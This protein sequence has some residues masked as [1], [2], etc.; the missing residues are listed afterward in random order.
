MDFYESIKEYTRE[1]V[2]EF[3]KECASFTK[4]SNNIDKRMK[5][6]VSKSNDMKYYGYKPIVISLNSKELL[7]YINHIVCFDEK[8]ETMKNVRDI[9]FKTSKM[10]YEKFNPHLI[11]TFANEINVVFYDNENGMFN[12]N[13]N[14]TITF[15]SS[16]ASVRVSNIIKSTGLDLDIH[17]TAKFTEFDVD[18]EV[19]NYLIWRQMDCRRNTITILYK[20]LHSEMILDNRINIENLKISSMIDE[21]KNFDIN[22]ETDFYNFLVGN[23]IKKHI[24][25][26]NDKVIKLEHFKFSDNFKDNYKN[27]I[28]GK[29]I[30]E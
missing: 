5:K 16:F 13:I 4:R 22:I 17:F 18:H 8:I 14:K 23:I 10:I 12:N 19:L 11:Y 25:S 1:Y 24:C 3:I 21:F 28:T 6:I 20:C 30:C 29:L 7:N 26:K 27:Y 15:L 2:N 9:L